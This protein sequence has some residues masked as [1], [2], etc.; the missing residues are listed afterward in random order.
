M[1]HSCTITDF[2]RYVFLLIFCLSLLLLSWGNQSYSRFVAASASTAVTSI[3]CYHPPSNSPV[4]DSDACA[5]FVR[6]FP[7]VTIVQTVENFPSNL[8][9]FHAV[10]INTGNT[11]LLDTHAAQL[12]AYV[13][14]G[15]GLIVSQPHFSSGSQPFPSGF[16]LTVADPFWPGFPQSPPP[17][18]QFTAAGAAH[19]ILSGLTPAAL[20]GNIQTIPVDTLG[21][22]WTL[23]AQSVNN[24]HAALAVG[25][26]G[27]GRLIFLSVGGSNDE[28]GDTF[29]QQLITWVIG[30]GTSAPTPTPMPTSSPT[31]A[32]T[33]T[34]EP[35][36]G[37]D[38]QIDA[39]EVTQAVQDLNNS[40]DLIANKRT[41]VRVHVSA[42]ETV[43]SVIANLEV[44]RDGKPLSPTLI[45]INPGG[46][47]MI[48]SSPDRRQLN[49]SFLFELPIEWVDVGL[50]TLEAT[51]DPNDTKDDPDLENNA[52]IVTVEF[53]DTPPLPL[54][55]YNVRYT[56]DGETY[57]TNDFH[58]SMA[59][60][61]L[62]RAFPISELAVNRT[63]FTYPEDSL[64]TRERL[65]SWVGVARW[66]AFQ[67]SIEPGTTYHYGL[68]DDG[69]VTIDGGADFIPG[70]VAVGPTGPTG[71]DAPILTQWDRDGSYGDWVM[72]HEMG[73][74]IGRFHADFCGVGA[75][76]YVAPYPHR[77]GRISPT[78]TGDRAIYGFDIETQKIYGPNWKD[79]MTYCDYKWVSD[80]T[81][82]GIREDMA[83]A[84][85][86]SNPA[87]DVDKFFIVSAVVDL[88]NATLEFFDLLL[89]EQ[90]SS[91][92]LS[93]EGEWSIVSLDSAD[94][95]LVAHAFT[96]QMLTHPEEGTREPAIISEAI[97]W[98]E[99]VASIQ[100]RDDATVVATK[101][102]STNAPTV[103]ITAPTQ[104]ESL[105]D[106]PLTF[107]WEGTD[108]DQDTLSY[109]VLYRHGADVD[110][111]L[112]TTNLMTP[113]FTI[114][115]DLLPGGSTSFLRI[116]ASD[117]FLTGEGTVGPFMVPAHEPT[118]TV[119]TPA[120]D[121]ATYYVGQ[122]VTLQGYGY[123]MEDGQLAGAAF[124]WASDI[125][126]NLGS[127]TM[128]QPT[129]LSSGD[130]T[131]TLTATDSDGNAVQVVR[132]LSIL[133]DTEVGPNILS[134]APLMVSEFAQLGSTTK[135]SA[136]FTLRNNGDDE[137]NWRA[138]TDAGWIS[139]SKMTDKTPTE[140]TVTVD[141]MG[142]PL[143]TNQGTITFEAADAENGPL[144]VP[145]ILEVT[146]E[147][148]D[149][150]A[151]QLYLP[152]L[153]N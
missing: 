66:L 31:S 90:P 117:G 129:D 46:D 84:Q 27:S 12:N 100:I 95:E 19:P 43:A 3:L 70:R 50:I 94:N 146:A 120:S 108:A 113:T 11:T 10:V 59:E 78:V 83:A 36:S 98:V 147:A 96:P 18:T 54:R 68:L 75:N 9:G 140:V 137:L 33:P 35:P 112:L 123:D 37:P 15:G 34:S 151:E 2:R 103:T 145:I 63:L 91:V 24:P 57:Q 56:V 135:I 89:V 143:G 58:M 44:R 1:F 62:R 42:P 150:T 86:A 74:L 13:N 77:L 104:N 130:H 116:I 118:V 22:A 61:W 128:I 93:A 80:F 53:L 82:E 8:S 102:A 141:P 105:G 121:G 134:V 115:A 107:E 133:N 72:G 142:L 132:T 30:E 55:L 14:G 47:I 41:Y 5:K 76:N 64:P 73:H 92:T 127:G 149:S 106:G 131:I 4:P 122:L 101:S 49:D 109:S 153:M 21:D 85:A 26:Y 65:I 119:E 25:E 111:A 52:K 138:N 32:P 139:L 114:D 6:L 28:K 136:N 88:S 60:S 99:G 110:W 40:V 69:G 144:V 71:P 67:F 87:V 45:P 7:D 125:D 20:A 79:L 16:E 81:Y 17:L 39:I 29:S 152:L 38:M 148:V 51:L 97:P 23:L 124:T 48:D 126:G